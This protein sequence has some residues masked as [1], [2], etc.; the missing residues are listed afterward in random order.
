MGH[1]VMYDYGREMEI[2]DD[3]PVHE[4]SLNY[5]GS[6]ECYIIE[7]DDM[8]DDMIKQLPPETQN[9][10]ANGKNYYCVIIYA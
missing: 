2:D 9:D 7:T 5:L 8:T 3:F 4:Y 1:Y 6:G 10:I